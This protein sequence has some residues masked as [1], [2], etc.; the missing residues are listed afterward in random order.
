MPS[1]GSLNIAYTG[2]NAHQQRLNVIGENITNVNTPGYHKQRVELSPI[3]NS[4]SGLIVGEFRSGG[5][6]EVTDIAR[7][8]DKTLSDHARAQ[9]ARAGSASE[10]SDILHAMEDLIGGLN[11]GGLH[12]QMTDLFN[13]FDDLAASPD[14]PALRRVV[15]QQAEILGQGFTRTG[16][17][18]DDLRSR[19]EEEIFDTVRSIN[20]LS[21]QI[22]SADAEILGANT[23][24][25]D[26]NTLTD[27]RD[28]MITEL[29]SLASVT[30]VEQADG[31][32][33]ISLDGQLLVSNGVSSEIDVV[34]DA[35]PALT[36]L[37]YADIKVVND[38][39]RE[40]N[41]T[42]GKL[43]AQMAA[44]QT[45]IPD[46]RRELDTVAEALVNQVN[47]VHS[48]GEGLDGSTGN[49]L[50]EIG[51][52]SGEVRISGDVVDQP[53]RVATRTLGA[54]QLDNGN[55]RELAQ[56]ADDPAGPLNDFVAMVGALAAKVSASDGQANAAEVAKSQDDTLALAAGGV[57]RTVDYL[58]RRG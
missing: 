25:A 9:G 31:Q 45:L 12:D 20:S 50:L 4:A 21:A 35:D 32:V 34:Y 13:S 38:R 11:D 15:L 14:D 58:F 3:H 8:R 10:T 37:G 49:N 7:V 18:L 40:L 44:T 16:A 23:I 17:D 19:V 57:E 41:A 55:V 36:P 27:Q 42:S 48:A 39:G 24:D 53:D 2:L 52:N 54:G 43:S 56:L 6:V 33:T 46:G 30:I 26:P 22:A 51:P 28:T 47:A 1:F 5:G 29:A